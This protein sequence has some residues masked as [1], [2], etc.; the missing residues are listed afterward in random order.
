MFEN[1]QR[2]QLA[3]VLDAWMRGDRYGTVVRTNSD[4]SVKVRLD[5]SRRLVNL[6]P[7][8]ISAV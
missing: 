1:A 5:R 2:V 4:G 8:D 7:R 3:P 6:L